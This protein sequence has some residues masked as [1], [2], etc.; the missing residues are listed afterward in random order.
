MV[1]P[2]LDMSGQV[3]NELARKLI[4]EF[5]GVFLFEI[6]GGAAP[7]RGVEAAPAN[8]FALAAV[9]YAFC[10]ISGGHINPAVSFALMLT[11]HQKPRETFLYIVIQ[12]L[13]AI[14]GS[15]M[16]SALIPGLW[17]GM[18]TFQ[19][20]TSPGCFHPSNGIN[21]GHAFMWEALMTMLLVLTVYGT[22]ACKPGHGS[23]APLA[24]GLSLYAA[25]L[26]GGPYTGASLNPA[27][28]IGPAVVYI[29]EG[30]AAIT[31]IFA[32]FFG[33]LLAAAFAVF[34]YGRSTTTVGKQEVVV[35]N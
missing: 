9:I 3:R 1:D 27:R 24:I 21:L 30:G 16:Y 22:A 10:N 34:V 12:V 23:L 25:A 32:E 28:T 7:P 8:G 2:Y 35:A 33:A 15:L 19:D 20:G 11:G 14:F 29:C 31:Y 26:T 18:P 5:V 4:A 17:P 6:F 13:G